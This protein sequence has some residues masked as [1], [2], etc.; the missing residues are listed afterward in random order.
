MLTAVLA[1]FYLARIGRNLDGSGCRR[2]RRSPS[3]AGWSCRTCSTSTS[4]TSAPT[5]RS[6][7]RSARSSS[8]CCGCSLSALVVIVGAEVNAEIDGRA[9]ARTADPDSR[10]VTPRVTSLGT[11]RIRRAPRL[12]GVNHLTHHVVDRLEGTFEV[13][14]NHFAAQRGKRAD[15]RAR[16]PGRWRRR[17][18]S[19]RTRRAGSPHGR[20]RGG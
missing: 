1:T 5:T 18:G 2:E 14:P 3:S 10:P 17:A 16:A 15:H 7:G 8:S 20:G 11:C 9:Q 4:R 13:T 6:T 12:D 19:G